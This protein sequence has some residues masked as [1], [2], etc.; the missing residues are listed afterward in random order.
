MEVAEEWGRTLHALAWVDPHYQEAIAK[1]R[2]PASCH[3]CH[4]P[5]PLLT[6]ATFLERGVPPQ[7]PAVRE[8]RPHQ[9]IDCRT[10]HQGADDVILG[11]WGIDTF[12][13]P[14]ER[15]ALMTDEGSNALCIACH[16]THIGPVI[17]VAKDFTATDQAA[18]GRTC[19]GCHMAP[20]VRS[21]AHDP[22]EE[23][24][25]P[26]RPGRSHLLQTPRDPAF[27]RQAFGLS[28]HRAEGGGVVV[29][30]ANRCGHR[31]PGL[32]GRELELL[33]TGFDG[34]SGEREEASFTIDR[35]SYLP[36]DEA[37]EIVLERDADRVRVRG[38]HRAPG[39]EEP[40]EFLDVE[41]VPG[42]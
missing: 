24:P 20:V 1:M 40:V 21:H 39:L 38:L 4:A 23:G 27:L 3:G 2:R 37:L 5:E 41:L 10:C 16:A 14:S 9:G 30:V 6:S 12:A 36:A 34:G 13:H 17:G 19:V 31:V 11:P 22:D 8:H 29:R 33:V 42:A 28:A 15:S 32:E 18:Q 26:E 7:K 35:A 25:A